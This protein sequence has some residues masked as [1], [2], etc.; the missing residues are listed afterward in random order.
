[1]TRYR[2]V[3]RCEPGRG[4][5][6]YLLEI[7]LHPRSSRQAPLV[8]VLKNPSTADATRSDPTIGKVEAW[9]RG[10]GFHRI[11][12]LNLFARRATHPSELNALHMQ[13]AVG[14]QNDA[15]LRHAA[16]LSRTIIV[17]WGNPNGID[18]AVYQ[19]RI[20]EVLS[21][22]KGHPLYRVGDL[23]RAGYP[24]HGLHW[25]PGLPLLPYPR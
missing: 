19:R 9:A 3:V 22:L 24:R 12:I 17:G 1:M 11:I 10:Q 20:E 14:P 8:A 25:N 2:Q 13:A 23:T 6:R 7:E 18:P 16:R 21:L 15:F 4:P 5:Y